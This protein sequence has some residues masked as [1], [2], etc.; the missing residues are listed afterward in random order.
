MKKK[1]NEKREFLGK[2]GFLENILKLFTG[3]Y[4]SKIKFVFSMNVNT[5]LFVW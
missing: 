1:I 4:S 3:L 5:I 2:I